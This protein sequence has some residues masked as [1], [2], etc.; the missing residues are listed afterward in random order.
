MIESMTKPWRAAH[1]TSVTEPTS[2]GSTSRFCDGSCKNLKGDLRRR[3]RLGHSESND[4]RRHEHDL[5]QSGPFQP[6]TNVGA[7]DG[8]K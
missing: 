1:T 3:R 7:S 2:V 4:R 6:E 8:S 5:V